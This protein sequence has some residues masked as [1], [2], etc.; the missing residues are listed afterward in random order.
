VR[1]WPE[2]RVSW[3]QRVN[4]PGCRHVTGA[5]LQ[6]LSEQRKH[7]GGTGRTNGSTSTRHPGDGAGPGRLAPPLSGASDANDGP[8]ADRV[9]LLGSRVF[10][11]PDVA[12]GGRLRLG[13]ADSGHF[14]SG[15]FDSGHFDSGTDEWQSKRFYGQVVR[16]Y[17]LYAPAR[18][19][20]FPGPDA[21]PR[22]ARRR[23]QRERSIGERPRP[24]R[25]QVPS[26][27]SRMPSSA[28]LWRE[29]SATDGKATGRGGEICCLYSPAWFPRVP[30]P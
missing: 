12:G 23:F 27:Q 29:P 16:L 8:G 21:R 18:H 7:R 4:G 28:P 11:W 30:G 24:E 22:R 2:G 14:D 6:L 3:L 20:R 19:R 1:S 25:P 5:A 13:V 10:E 9:G 26:G 17:G 15:H